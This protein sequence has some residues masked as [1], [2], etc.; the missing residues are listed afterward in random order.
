M[1]I[2]LRHV[3]ATAIAW[4]RSAL[5]AGG[6]T[7]ASLAQELCRRENW[8]NPKGDRCLASAR[9]ALPRIASA[10]D[11]PLPP[12]RDYPNLAVACSLGELGEV[13]VVPQATGEAPL[14]RAMLATWHPEGEARTPG[15]RVSYWIRSPRLGR[16]GLLVFCVA[17]WHQK[18][19]DT[20][21]GWSQSA[22][23]AHLD[24]LVVN[25]RFLLLPSVK[26]EGLAS[27]VLALAVR[28]LPGDWQARY[29]V[30]PLLACTYVAPEHAGTSYLA[31]GWQCCPQR[32]SGRAGV[33]R[34]VWMKPLAD[35]W[36]AVPGA[37]G[38]SGDKAGAGR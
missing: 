1:K 4:L 34:S 10:L 2:G 30:R 23:D 24:K 26:V 3:S 19:R 12:L 18:A 6:Q 38:S 14:A 21:I 36:R 37:G 28:R 29:G 32:T 9:V 16:L 7:R 27:H 8:R 31:A 35:D 22:R 33:R 5:V 11:L 25:D 20:F 13:G 17:G 15:A